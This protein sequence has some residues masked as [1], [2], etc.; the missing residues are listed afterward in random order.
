[1]L[2]L[3][4]Q[5][6]LYR[7]VKDHSRPHLAFLCKPFRKKLNTTYDQNNFSVIGVGKIIGD[8]SIPVSN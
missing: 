1:M 2:G 7:K 6:V 3:L 8:N 4:V 5:I